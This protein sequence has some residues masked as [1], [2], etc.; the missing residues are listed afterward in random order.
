MNKKVF[1][2]IILLLLTSLFIAGCG[3]EDSGTSNDTTVDD[4]GNVVIVKP[5]YIGFISVTPETIGLK[6]TGNASVSETTVLKFKA[7]KSVTEVAPGA[8][9]KFTISTDVGGLSFSPGTAV[10]DDKGEVSVTVKSGDVLTSFKITATSVSDPAISSTSPEI[11]VTSPAVKSI[12]FISTDLTLIALKGTGGVAGTANYPLSETAQLIFKARDE[13]GNIVTGAEISFT[14]T[15]TVGGVALSAQTQKTDSNGEVKIN[16]L[17]GN[18]PTS[19]SVIA[20]LVS[21]TNIR[22]ISNNIDVSTGRPTPRGFNF[23]AVNGNHLVGGL[24]KVGA[25]KD[26]TVQAADIFGHPVPDGTIVSF[27]TEWGLITPFCEL[28]GGRCT[29]TLKSGGNATFFNDQSPQG[30]VTVVASVFGEE[31]F[32]DVNSN[33]V[34]DEE[35]HAFWDPTRDNLA[36]EMFINKHDIVNGS[37]NK[38]F[39][40]GIDE[41]VDENSNGIWDAELDSVYTGTLC[42][43]N[44]AAAG[45][46]N[47]KLITIW[48]DNVIILTEYSPVNNSQIAFF[49]SSFQALNAID[50]QSSSPI[51]KTYYTEVKDQ[52]GNTLP[53]DSKIAISVINQDGSTNANAIITD[54]SEYTLLNTITPGYVGTT[55]F[56]FTISNRDKNGAA[57]PA[58]SKIHVTVSGQGTNTKDID[59]L[60]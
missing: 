17:S 12:Q 22:S 18:I 36:S 41:Y 2:S 40:Y 10:T 31:S 50:L 45:L 47:K 27:R 51:Q 39:D 14:L 37:T 11:K 29:V 24:S 1:K 42:T 34:Y 19:V 60:L 55:F 59:I 25:E 35:D 33:G 21:D 43:D 13:A 30:R 6:G 4:S 20:S 46:C 38:D 7:W 52:N 49:D 8:T 58:G 53:M 3:W 57:L 23:N 32:T 5:T 15:T 56:R 9:I 28:I 26:L 16:V 54:K 44:A 48:S